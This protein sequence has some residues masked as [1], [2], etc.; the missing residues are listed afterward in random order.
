[1]VFDTKCTPEPEQS[2]R[3]H[4]GAKFFRL[5]IACK[6]KTNFFTSSCPA[7]PQTFEPLIDSEEAAA[8]LGIHAKTLIRLARERKI[9]AVR[10]GRL[11]RFRT[12]AMETWIQSSLADVAKG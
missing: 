11:W 12:S 4:P 5:Q 7:H 10:L 6:P 9:P 2:L 8:L 3:G 1:L